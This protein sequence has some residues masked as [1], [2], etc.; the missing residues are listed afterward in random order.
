MWWVEGEEEV[1]NVCWRK[2]N[3]LRLGSHFL[4]FICIIC[5]CHISCTQTLAGNGKQYKTI[6]TFFLH[7]KAEHVPGLRSDL[8][9]WCD[10]EANKLRTNSQRSGPLL[11]VSAHMYFWS[12]GGTALKKDDSFWWPLSC[13][14]CR[15]SLEW[16]TVGQF[17]TFKTISLLG[18]A[19]AFRAPRCDTKEY[20]HS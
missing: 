11:A 2:T 1:K 13:A 9:T 18:C 10:K 3:K 7:T 14:L 5:I 20:L 17:E 15:G 16:L 4:V 8:D 12:A 19:D 6:H